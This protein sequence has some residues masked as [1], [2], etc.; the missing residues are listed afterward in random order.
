MNIELLKLTIVEIL[1]WITTISDQAIK[2][3]FL[4]DWLM[5]WIKPN[6]KGGGNNLVSNYWSNMVSKLYSTITK[7]KISWW[8]ECH[9]K[10]ALGQSFFR[11]KHSTIDHLDTLRFSTKESWLQGRTLYLLFCGLQESLWY[12]PEEQ[13]LEKNDRDQNAIRI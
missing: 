13:V 6:H 8:V 12:C 1:E 10:Q 9:H 2:Q 4:E 11:T 5:H 7:Q 3:S